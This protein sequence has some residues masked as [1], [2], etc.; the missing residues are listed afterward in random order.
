MAEGPVI[1]L[2]DGEHHPAAV[3]DALDRLDDERGL[4]GVVFCGGEEKL[5]PAPLDE[6]YGRPV[7]EGAEGLRE[8]APGARRW[9]IWPT[10]RCCPRAPGCAWPRW[11]FTSGLAYEAPGARLE[12]PVYEAGAVRRSQAGG[13]R[14][15]KAHRQDRGGRPLG[16]AA[17]RA[18]RRSGRSSA[19]VAA[20]PPSRW[21]PS[22]APASTSCSRSPTG[23]ATRR[24]TTWRTPCW[25][26]CARWA[27]GGWAA[28]WP[29]RRPSRTCPPARPS[30]PRCGP[31]RSSSRARGPASRPV[32]VDR[33]VCLVGA[34]PPE[35]FADY[36]L[37][38]A[39]LV[40][41]AEGARGAAA[42]RDHH[43]AA[44]RSRQSRCRPGPRVALFTTGGP[45]RAGARAGGDLGQP[46][47]PPRA[48]RRSRPR[49]RRAL[50]RVPHRAEGGGHRHGRPCEPGPRARG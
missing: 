22:P 3:R 27:A 19:W 6:Q 2:V 23:E 35:P 5:G 20:V 29:A 11:R 32:E 40:L 25:P 28:G 37:L 17:A 14:H 4:A 34:G 12:P 44:R 46:G 10:S 26:G 31:A 41:A 7:R 9:S 13:D 38:R 33:T 1:A 49:G 50:R 45:A 36:R 21:W 18:R 30:P 16:R 42:R 24:P 8:L 39:D 47:P 43:L 15:R 48:G